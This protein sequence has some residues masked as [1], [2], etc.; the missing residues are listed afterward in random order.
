MKDIKDPKSDAANPLSTE[1]MSLLAIGTSLT[2]DSTLDDQTVM[3]VK[4]ALMDRVRESRASTAV[5]EHPI[6]H[7]DEQ[8]KSATPNIHFKVLRN[9]GVTMSWLLK[10]LP[11][12]T[13]PAH[14]HDGGDE[15]SL[16]MEGS[17]R[18]DGKM[19]YPGDYTVARKSSGHHDIYSEQGCVVFLTSRGSSEDKLALMREA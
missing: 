17:L 5:S 7:R 4:R 15:E 19:L 14:A 1:W 6:I 13:L 16:V 12:T 10:L 11:G 2:P 9:D 18:L 8:W 3:Q